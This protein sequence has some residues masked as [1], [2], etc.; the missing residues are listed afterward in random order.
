MTGENRPK[1]PFDDRAAL[2]ELERLQR[3]IQEYRRRREQVEGEF[4][5]FV[6]SFRAPGEPK[7]PPSPAPPSAP[8]LPGFHRAPAVRPAVPLSPVD[9][10][11]PVPAASPV[12]P[13]P[14]ATAAAAQPDWMA[15]MATQ[16]P[17]ARV[18]ATSAEP[19]PPAVTLPNRF[20]AANEPSS[21]GASVE[22]DA[23]E[24]KQRRERGR[25]PLVLGALAIALIAAVL[26]TRAVYAP[27][28]P[29]TAPAPSTAAPAPVETPP[30]AAP[31]SAPPT[32]VAA[33]PASVDSPAA[34]AALPPPPA[35]IRTIRAVWVR[36]IVDGNREVER[37][38]EADARVP[39]PAGRVFVVRAGDAG[40]VRFLLNGRDQGPLGADA[41]VVTRTFTAPER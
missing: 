15:G 6:G 9:A 33:P 32:Q 21:G 37:E 35:E 30:A 26:L 20:F 25:L 4:E 17:G 12:A 36:V 14:N 10:V 28:S 40:A 5:Q 18:T 24:T 41:Q 23:P 13:Q 11:P 31:S 3:S 34:P 39:L 8:G 16:T 19:P 38:L 22:P 1:V 7:Q 2:E 29:S 27:V